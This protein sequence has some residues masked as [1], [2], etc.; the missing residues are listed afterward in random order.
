MMLSKNPTFVKH[1]IQ[2]EEALTS[3]SEPTR[4]NGNY[5]FEQMLIS[6]GELDSMLD[7]ANGER[8][9]PMM[10]SVRRDEFHK[11]CRNLGDWLKEYVPD[12]VLEWN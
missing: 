10:L 1:R 7:V 3:V 9:T 11:H 8:P 12:L 5:L 4:S 2:I 6:A